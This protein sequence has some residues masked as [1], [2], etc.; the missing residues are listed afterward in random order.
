M[1]ADAGEIRCILESPLAHQFYYPVEEMVP[2]TVT[3]KTSYIPARRFPNGGP[4]HKRKI[5]AQVLP[6][7]TLAFACSVPRGLL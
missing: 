4:L 3:L 5:S 7:K 2:K 6:S 1:L